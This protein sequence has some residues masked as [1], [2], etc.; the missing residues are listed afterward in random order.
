[1]KSS[2]AAPVIDLHCDLSS[3]IS[4]WPDAQPLDPD[5]IGC[6]FPRLRQGHVA[7]QVLAMYTDGSAESPAG[8]LRQAKVIA[9][10]PAQYPDYCYAA[11]GQ[12]PQLTNGKTAL[13]A[14]I[15]SAS[16]LAVEGEPLDLAFKRLEAIVKLAGPLLYISFTHHKANRFGGG[17]YEEGPLTADGQ[18]LLEYMS[19]RGIALDLS[20]A[21]DALGRTAID[22][23]EKKGLQVPV[24]ASHSNFRPVWNHVRNLPD[25]LTE[26]IIA[27]KGL[28]G[29]NFLRAYVDDDVPDRLIEHI[30]YGLNRGAEQVL[31]IGADYFKVSSHPNPARIPFFHEGYEHA[32]RNPE[33]LA[34][35]A[36][37]GM[38]QHVQ[39]LAHGNALR[40]LQQHWAQA[41][42]LNEP[43][44]V[45]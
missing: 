30:Q 29:M 34:K 6:S 22:F 11:Q 17:N 7:L 8:A 14:A 12:L 41:S 23:I 13:V 38:E 26:Y 28:I 44:A 40:F 25:D 43:S 3:Y 21:S 18:A 32:G 10:L 9:N 1:M 45:L 37:A 5:L 31:A 2:I 16:G 20:H 39:A 35:V 36:K 24:I 4:E 15:E 42:S 27:N 33:V 19:G